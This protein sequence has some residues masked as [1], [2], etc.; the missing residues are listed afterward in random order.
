MLY[1]AKLF[2]F[3]GIAISSFMFLLLGGYFIVIGFILFVLLYI[4]GDAFL[5]DDFSE[6]SLNNKL[7]INCM[8]YSAVPLAFGLL[9]ICAWLLDPS[10]NMF[11]QELGKVFSYNF[12]D[13]KRATQWWQIIVA[14]V[15]AGL[16]LSGVA[17]VVGHELV[18]RIGKKSDVCLGRWLMSMCLD[19]NFSIEHVYNHHAKVATIF[20]SATAPRGRNVY[21]HVLLALY[22]TNKSAWLIEVKRLSRKKYPLISYHNRFLRGLLMSISILIFMLIFF[23]WQSMLMVFLVGLSAKIILEIV[24]YIEHYG[25]VRDLTSPVEPKHSWNTNRRV[26]CWAMFNLPR[27]S[28]HHAN[29]KLPFEKLK[30]L[31]EAPTMINGYI[32]SILIALLPPLWFMLMHKKLNHW[33]QHFANEK[34]LALLE[35]HQNTASHRVRGMGSH[36]K[37]YLKKL[38][39]L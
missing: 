21:L 6:P 29:A 11:M 10:D 18:H 37:H 7:F 23:S 1:Y 22:F 5:G 12:Y 15:Y 17:S 14:I 26:S 16:L 27:H 2:H 25:L 9:L 35:E 4:L 38:N 33:D 34:E 13:A 39:I 20:D 28:F 3:Y 31:P 32:T 30:S 19:A 8:L 24:N 36:L